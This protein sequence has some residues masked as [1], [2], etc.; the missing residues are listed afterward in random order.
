MDDRPSHHI[1]THATKRPLRCP[2][3]FTPYGAPRSAAIRPLSTCRAR[4][5]LRPPV[6]PPT[7]DPGNSTPPPVRINHRGRGRMG[8]FLESERTPGWRAHPGKFN[9]HLKSFKKL[10]TINLILKKLEMTGG[11]MDVA[12]KLPQ[13]TLVPK[14]W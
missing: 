10:I 14:T 7:V 5:P 13:R 4:R 12:S 2:R 11:A 6:P 3:T 9:F 8:A 1:G